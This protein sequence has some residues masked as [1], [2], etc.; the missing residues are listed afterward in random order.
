MDDE[1]EDF[2]AH[3]IIDVDVGEEDLMDEIVHRKDIAR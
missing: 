3:G 1:Q 2:L